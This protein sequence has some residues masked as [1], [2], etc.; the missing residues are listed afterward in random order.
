[1]TVSL[2]SNAQLK[3]GIKGGVN[4]CN[5]IISNVD[6]DFPKDAYKPKISYHFGSFV[7]Y[8]FSKQFGLQFEVLF[9]NKGYELELENSTSIISLNYLNWPILIYY[10]PFKQLEIEFGPEF[11]YLITGEP[12][13][14]SFDMGFDIGLRYNISEKV[15]AGIRYN[16]GV[17]FNM[18]LDQFDQVSTEP[19]YANSVFQIYLGFNLINEPDHPTTKK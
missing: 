13:V 1:M 4:A 17:A 11:G 18:N 10:K 12:L 15:N 3:G 7:N 5:F 2:T 16:Q 8:S 9:S 19:K 6:S 14:N